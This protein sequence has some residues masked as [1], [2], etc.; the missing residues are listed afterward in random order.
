[1]AT[2]VKK[3]LVGPMCCK[4][5]HFKVPFYGYLVLAAILTGDTI[6]CVFNIIGDLIPV[7]AWD[8]TCSSCAM[9]GVCYWL[10]HHFGVALG[11]LSPFA[12]VAKETIEG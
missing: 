11:L 5:N 2:V 1:V 7:E 4:E 10:N 3:L 8:S 9:P 6:G 12:M